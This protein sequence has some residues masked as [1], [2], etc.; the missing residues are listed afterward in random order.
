VSNGEFILPLIS[1]SFPVAA[2]LALKQRAV[3]RIDNYCDIAKAWRLL[4]RPL[5]IDQRLRFLALRIILPE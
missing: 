3:S 1:Q 5:S 2:R 4:H